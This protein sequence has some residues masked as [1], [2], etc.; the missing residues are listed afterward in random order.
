MDVSV[1][2][3]MP[4]EISLP[5]PALLVAAGTSFNGLK[6][7]AASVP[8]GERSNSITAA[9]EMTARL[10]VAVTIPA[11]H[12]FMFVFRCGFYWVRGFPKG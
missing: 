4:A 5:L 12:L 8:A 3:L 9:W 11:M 1:S 6:P 7:T 10:N 2:K